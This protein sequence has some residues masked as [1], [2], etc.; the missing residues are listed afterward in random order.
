M[1]KIMIV[2]DD[3]TIGEIIDQRLQ[4]WGYQTYRAQDYQ[5]IVAEF[6]R[7]SPHLILLDLNL[8]Y[9]DGFYW[10]GRIRQLS[11]VPIIVISSRDSDSDKIRAIV[12]GGDD[13]LEKPFSLDLL[14]AKVQASLRRAYS[15]QDHSLNVL[16]YKDQILDPERLLIVCGRCR[17][18][19]TPNEAKIL[20]VLIR[21]QERTVSRA[22]LIKSL[23]DDESFVDDNTLTVNVNRLRKKL[24]EVGCEQ[25]LKTVKGEGYVLK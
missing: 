18:E 15:Y 19:L 6:T 5:N 16:Q 14:I 23:W 9:F 13:Y 4:K 20:A 11:H 1:Y 7:Y 24:S 2:E 22:Y 10:C 17:V 12:Q 3:P 21:N 25:Y 8:P